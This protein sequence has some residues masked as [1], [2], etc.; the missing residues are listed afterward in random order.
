MLFRV[1]L[2]SF[3]MLKRSFTLI[4]AKSNYM[5]D[6]DE[7]IKKATAFEAELAALV[8]RYGV[9]TYSFVSFFDNGS[10]KSAYPVMVHWVREGIPVDSENAGIIKIAF[11]GSVNIIR[12]L[13]GKGLI[14]EYYE[15]FGRFD[16]G[17]R[18]L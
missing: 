13:T 6:K 16:T 7:M 8:K 14:H 2:I 11:T 3:G 5:S 18:D 12:T 9:D 17:M 10:G 1:A 4:N 15:G